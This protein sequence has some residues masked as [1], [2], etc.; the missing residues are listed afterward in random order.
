MRLILDTLVA[1]M[2][3]G[4]F[5]GV[6]VHRQ[7]EQ[8]V[9]ADIEQTA[10]SVRHLEQQVMLQSQLGDVDLTRR[11]YPA[12]MEPEWFTLLP[13]N[14]LVGAGHPWVELAPTWQRDLHHPPDP[15]AA[16]PDH[17][18]FWYN[19]STGSVRA[20]VPAALTDREALKVYNRINGSDLDSL[21]PDP[22]RAENDGTRH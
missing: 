10:E 15:V 13:D 4:I 8:R 2:V 7:T 3:T 14:P 20:R 22:A 21:H 18:R 12:T 16:T 9:E 6:V 1:L 11:G 5:A 19:P 17:A